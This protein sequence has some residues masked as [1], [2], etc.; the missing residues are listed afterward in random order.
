MCIIIYAPAGKIVPSEHFNNSFM[1]NSD[2]AGVMYN[3]K[4]NVIIHKGFM[5]IKD[6]NEFEATLPVDCDRVYHFRIATSGKIAKET[7]HPYPVVNNLKNMLDIDTMCDVGAAHNGIVSWCTPV[8]ALASSFSDSMVFLSS[9]VYPHR[10]TLFKSESFRELLV[11]ASC[12]KFAFMNKDTV[13]LVGSFVEED[14]IF[15]SNNT[16][17]YSYMGTTYHGK[18]FTYKYEDDDGFDNYMFKGFYGSD[19]SVSKIKKNPARLHTG[20]VET[21]PI[22]VDGTFEEALDALEYETTI[23]NFAMVCFTPTDLEG[24]GMAL[25]DVDLLIQILLDDIGIDVMNFEYDSSSECIYVALK[26]EDLSMLPSIIDG[27]SWEVV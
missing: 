9:Y 2:G 24:Y 8:K 18:G 16:Y 1:C 15:Y 20:T 7:C 13:K 21:L 12:S 26:W 3:D 17:K 27:L 19:S 10:N 22:T 5:N 6:F 14:G 23:N 11:H 25:S 4:E